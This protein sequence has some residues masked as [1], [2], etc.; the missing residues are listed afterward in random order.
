MRNESW[1]GTDAYNVGNYG[2]CMTQ[3][4]FALLKVG[5]LDG[6]LGQ[7]FT[8]L[9]LQ[10]EACFPVDFIICQLVGQLPI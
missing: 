6:W 3:Y 9:L 1:K 5:W 4:S 8:V 10:K 7:M 2:Q